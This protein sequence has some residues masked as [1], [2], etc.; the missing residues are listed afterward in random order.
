MENKISTHL[1]ARSKFKSEL[2]FQNV[3]KI[4]CLIHKNGDFAHQKCVQK[5]FT[6]KV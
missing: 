2:K 1:S 6:I 3:I 5:I 4:A